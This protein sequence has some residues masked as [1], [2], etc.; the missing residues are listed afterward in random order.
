MVSGNKQL[1]MFHQLFRS[2]SSP[3]PPVEDEDNINAHREDASSNGAEEDE[4]Q[5]E[6]DGEEFAEEEEG[7]G[8]MEKNVHQGDD[9]RSNKDQTMTLS[10][11]VSRD[12]EPL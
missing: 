2:G 8:G 9:H 12:L 6:E 3:N 4:M 1:R 7:Y 11:Y 5:M 10:E